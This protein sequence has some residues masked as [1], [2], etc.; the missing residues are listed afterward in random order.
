MK[1]VSYILL[2]GG[3]GAM[4]KN[5]VNVLEQ[6]DGLRVV[7]TSRQKKQDTETTEYRQGNAH[8]TE[9]LWHILQEREWDAIVD[10]MIYTTEEFR[11]RVELLLGA[12]KQYVYISS[13]RVYADSGNKPITEDSPRLLDVCNDTEYLQ[14]DEYALT[15]ARQEDLLIHNNRKNWT[16]IRPYITFS[17]NRLQL[18]V[19]E[20][21]DWLIPALNNRPIVFSKD[22]AE[23]FTTM[24]DGY[25]VA[26]GIAAILTNPNAT[27]EVFHI[28]SGQS[29]KWS[30]ILKWYLETIFAIKGEKPKVY[31][32][33]EWN[34]SFGG[35]L[36]Q[37]KY[38]RLYNRSFD[39]SKICKYVS[40]EI[41]AST[42]L[43]IKEAI[44]HFVRNY[45]PNISDLD[46]SRE[47]R[48]GALTGDY[49]PLS[50]TMGVKRKLKLIA[51]KIH[52]FK[53]LQKIY[54]LWN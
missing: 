3:T 18:G 38:D 2:L 53:P 54:H 45:M 20:K 23:H 15:K 16:I 31:Y 49:L 17:D 34:P 36:Y 24:T 13:A 41:F 21:E 48:R 12:T 6:Q 44:S 29:L 46:Q 7:V 19:M 39:N 14:T 43:M 52:I 10:F 27:G 42:E 51:Y 11:S 47:L 22:I 5:L 40:N 30:D 26:Q 9:W 8:D 1:K 35:A 4:G 25:A 33:E 28:A 50:K 32:T 37:W